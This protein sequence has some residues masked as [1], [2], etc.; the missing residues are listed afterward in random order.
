M[1]KIDLVTLNRQEE[2]SIRAGASIINISGRSCGCACVNDYIDS[3]GQWAGNHTYDNSWANY[4]SL[5]LDEQMQ[6]RCDKL[7]IQVNTRIAWFFKRKKTI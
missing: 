5:G 7:T 3:N 4:D 2:D 1:T 6:G